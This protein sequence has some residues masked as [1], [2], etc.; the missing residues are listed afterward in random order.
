[1]PEPA[2][3]VDRQE[4]V[5][6][7]TLNRPEHRNAI[8]PTLRLQLIPALRA[9]NEDSETRAVVLTGAGGHFCSGGDLKAMDQRDLVSV[10]ER[11]RTVAELVMLIRNAPK[12]YIAAVSGVAFGAGL[13]L[14]LACDQIIATPSARFCAA[15][16]KVGLTP[17][18]GLMHLLPRR[19]GDGAARRMIMTACELNS[20]QAITMGLIDGLTSEESLMG[21]AI[22]CAAE[23]GA[24]APL[25]LHLV[26]ATMASGWTN[27][28][29]ST[30]QIEPNLMT[31]LFQSDDFAEAVNAF[32]ERREPVFKSR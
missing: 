1:M 27:T 11:M 32:K 21:S 13:S 17:D 4:A 24:H 19:V 15:F 9:A 16:V 26:K 10:H 18:Y 25:A 12:P 5:S 30:L 2:I 6:I 23:F 22:A 31:Q 3:L 28:L 8:N 20:D 29:E 7:I 14:A